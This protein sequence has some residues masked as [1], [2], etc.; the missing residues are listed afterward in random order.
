MFRATW[1]RCCGESFSAAQPSDSSSDNKMHAS[2]TNETWGRVTEKLLLSVQGPGRSKKE[3]FFFKD[4]KQ[5]LSS[6][7]KWSYLAFWGPAQPTSDNQCIP[8]A[9]N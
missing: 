4:R 2:R 3:D 8:L 6:K 7:A 5:L 1:N 9:S